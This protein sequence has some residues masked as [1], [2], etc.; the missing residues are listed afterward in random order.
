M[1]LDNFVDIGKVLIPKTG[2]LC[3]ISD[4]AQGFCATPGMLYPCAVSATV[5]RDL[6]NARNSSKLDSY[7][8]LSFSQALDLLKCGARLRW[9]DWQD[10]WFVATNVD[11]TPNERG[12]MLY[13]AID[14]SS[15]DFRVQDAS[16]RPSD[17]QMLWDGW[18]LHPTQTVGYRFYL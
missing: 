14:N 4:A 16:W 13:E 5:L 8:R 7:H 17:T 2:P 3:L 1:I 12:V 10:D 9:H 18:V 6:M 15:A 11:A